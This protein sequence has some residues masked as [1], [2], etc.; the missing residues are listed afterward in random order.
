MLHQ[1]VLIS[2]DYINRNEME[3]NGFVDSIGATEHDVRV[4]FGT[5]DT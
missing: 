1:I 3:K 5:A 4:A 2:P